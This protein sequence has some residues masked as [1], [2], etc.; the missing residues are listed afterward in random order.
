[1]VNGNPG[2]FPIAGFLGE[3]VRQRLAGEQALSLTPVTVPPAGPLRSFV[4]YWITM[5]AAGTFT[6]CSVLGVQGLAAQVL[7]RR[8][9]LRVSRL[10]QLGVFCALVSGYF[11]QRPPA[12][13]LLTG[14]RQ[15][16]L[17]WI[18]SYWF[19][20]MYQQLSGAL[21]PALMPLAHRCWMGL[22]LAVCAAAGAYGASYVRTL[23]R[24]VEEPDLYPAHRARGLP[25]FT[26]AFANAVL[27]FSLRSLY[28]SRQHRMIFAFYLG[29]GFAFLILFLSAPQ[30]VAGSTSADFWR[31]PSVP[32]LAAT[33]LLMGFWVVGA[34]VVF[35]LP[36]ELRANW[37]F[38][39]MPFAAGVQCLNARRRALIVASVAPAWVISAGLLGSGWPWRPVAVHLAV[40]ASLGMVLA[41]FSLDGIQRLP[42]ACSYLQGRSNLHL[43][44]WLWIILLLAG[45]VVAAVNELRAFESLAASAALVFGSGTLA[46]FTILRNNRLARPGSAELR[47]EEQPPD[48]LQS[49]NLS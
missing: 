9:Y 16:W 14:P 36:L 27:R 1:L 8:W 7:S 4:A 29:V 49:L 10:V 43:T 38:R 45:V 41:E 47:F 13:V 35:S 18:P 17:S 44:F 19:V 26:G 34:R 46:V 48:Q 28:R 25:R 33:L 20:G 21:H 31:Q 11:L 40:L 12:A 2:A 22:A 3:H 6:F 15:P 5:L 30:E 23:R 24:I 42:F 37:I 32:L 39:V